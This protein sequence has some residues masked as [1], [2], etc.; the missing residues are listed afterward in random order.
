MSGLVALSVLK[1]SFR[2]RPSTLLVARGKK[3]VQVRKHLS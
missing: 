3:E 1:D 2:F